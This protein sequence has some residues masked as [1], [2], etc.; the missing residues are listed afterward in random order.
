MVMTFYIIEIQYSLIPFSDVFLGNPCRVHEHNLLL[1]FPTL[2]FFTIILSIRQLI[3]HA[4]QHPANLSQHTQTN[5]NQT[6]PQPNQKHTDKKKKNKMKGKESSPDQPPNK[7]QEKQL[8]TP[9]YS[10][11]TKLD[12]ATMRPG[13]TKQNHENVAKTKP[14]PSLTHQ[15]PRSQ[16][17][18]AHNGEGLGQQYKKVLSPHSILLPHIS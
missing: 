16:T 3:L 13:R 8:P 4:A 11:W 18:H 12:L 1:F 5:Q 2:S 7:K 15:Q 6:L 17:N 10:S 14:P 9:L